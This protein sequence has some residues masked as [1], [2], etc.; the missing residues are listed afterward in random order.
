MPN[1]ISH[2]HRI[3]LGNK[4]TKESKLHSEMHLPKRHIW[5]GVYFYLNVKNLM[6][7]ADIVIS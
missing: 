1:S 7:M 4:Q 3:L 2:L 6:D 5:N